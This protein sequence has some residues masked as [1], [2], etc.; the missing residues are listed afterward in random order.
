V[1]DPLA[2]AVQAAEGDLADFVFREH[3]IDGWNEVVL[4][5]FPFFLWLTKNVTVTW[6]K[7][8]L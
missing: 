7:R 1:A 4:Y 2:A 3:F 5:T 8:I 6:T